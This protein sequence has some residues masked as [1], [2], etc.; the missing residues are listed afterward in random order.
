MSKLGT[1]KLNSKEAEIAIL[2]Q[3]YYQGA[4][5]S[6]K[7]CETKVDLLQSLQMEINCTALKFQ[8]E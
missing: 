8:S 2:Q 6:L 4:P 7:G 5:E 1:S 3:I